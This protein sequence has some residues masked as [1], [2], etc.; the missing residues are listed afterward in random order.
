MNWNKD[1]PVSFRAIMRLASLASLVAA[2][3]HQPGELRL[4]EIDATKRVVDGE[5]QHQRSSGEH[6]LAV[7]PLHAEQISIVAA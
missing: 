6:R 1:G 5:L 3:H 2:G 7:S 4:E